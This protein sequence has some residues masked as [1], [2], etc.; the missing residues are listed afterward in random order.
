MKNYIHFFDKSGSDMNLETVENTITSLYD[1]SNVVYESLTGS[2]FFPKV[3]AGLIESQNFYL[4]QDVI[5]PSNYTLR[6]L[7]GSIVVTAGNP[8]V[9]GTDTEF[10]SLYVGNKIKIENDDY[11]ITSIM[12]DETMNVSSY[13]TKDYDTTNFYLYEYK[14]YVKPRTSTGTYSE[15]LSVSIPE[16]ST[17]IDDTFDKEV[18]FVYDIDYS[19]SVPWIKK[20]RESTY[21]L[22]DGS[23][24]SVDEN[25]G[26]VILSDIST[27]PLQINIGISADVEYVYDEIANFVLTKEYQESLIGA[28]ID[29]DYDVL[30]VEGIDHEFYDVSIFYLEGGIGSSTF[31]SESVDVIE[32]GTSGSNTY[33]K[34]EKLDSHP[35]TSSNFSKYR[36]RW[37]NDFKLADLVLYGEIEGEDERLKMVLEN[38][39]KKLDYANEYIFRDSD[40]YE[41]SPDYV[42]LNKKRKELLLEGDNIYP[43]LG[44]YKALLNIINFFGYYDMET[45]EYFLNVDESSPNYNKYFQVKI[46]KNEDERE[47]LKGIWSMLPSSVYKKTSLF[48][49]F[50]KINEETGEYDEYGIPEVKDSYDFSSEEIL[51]KLF[52]LKEL[53]KK[54]YLPLN[55][56]IYDITGEGIYFKRIRLDSWADNLCTRS[57][58]LGK[59]PVFSVYPETD[60]YITDI[61]R[62]DDFYK[63]SIFAEQGLTGFLNEDPSDPFVTPATY[64]GTLS[65]LYD[66]TSLIGYDSFRRSIYDSDGNFNDVVDIQ[67][68]YFPEGI[69]D[70]TFNEKAARKSLIPDSEGILTGAPILLESFF[71]ITYDEANFTFDNISVFDTSGNPLNTNRWTYDNIGMG[72]YIDMRWKVEKMEDSNSSGF[73]YDSGRRTIESFVENVKGAT[74]FAMNAMALCDVLDGSIEN[75]RFTGGCGYYSVPIVKVNAPP[76]YSNSSATSASNIITVS[77]TEGLGIGMSVTVAG[78]TGS[79]HSGTVVTEILGF[80]T[81]MV[82]TVPDDELQGA[83]IVGSGIAPEIHAEIL[84]GFVIALDVISSGL[85][86]SSSPEIKIAAPE[87]TYEYDRRILNAIALPYT[88]TYSISL[89]NYDVTNSFTLEFQKYEVK[90]KAVDFSAIFK[91]KVPNMTIDESTMTYDEMNGLWYYQNVS[92]TTFDEMNVSFDSFGF[93]AFLNEDFEFLPVSPTLISIDRENLLIE[94]EEDLISGNYN[95]IGITVGDDIFFKR[96][97]S[98]LIFKNELIEI[99]NVGYDVYG[100]S[101]IAGENVIYSS[102]SFSEFFGVGCF[103]RIN[104]EW[105]TVS[106]I[107]DSRF[108]IEETLS[109][110]FSGESGKFILSDGTV[111]VTTDDDVGDVS[112]YSRMI[113]SDNDSYEDIQSDLSYYCYVDFLEKN[114]NELTVS[115]KSFN[116]KILVEKSIIENLYVSNGLF[117]GTYSLEITNAFISNEHTFL[118]V[119]DPTNELYALDGNFSV[120]F[121]D[122]DADYAENRIGL[123]SMFMNNM[124]ESTFEEMTDSSFIGCMYNPDVLCGFVIT[125]I[126]PG[127]S[128][129]IDENDPFFFSGDQELDSSQEGLKK[130]AIELN[131]SKNSGIFK[132]SYHVLPDDPLYVVDSVGNNLFVNIDASYG[133][134]SIVL[135]GIPSNLEENDHVWVGNEW[136]KISSISDNTVVFDTILYYDVSSG[137][138]PF[139]PYNYHRQ[140]YENTDIFR[141]YYFFIHGKGKTSSNEELSYVTMNGNVS[142]EWA[143]HPSKTNT[144]PLL[145]SFLQKD[146]CG[147]DF[148]CQ[149]HLYKKWVYEG[150]DYPPSEIDYD[151][152]SDSISEESRLSYIG[153]LENPFFVSSTIVTSTQATVT[154]TTPIIFSANSCKIPGKHDFVWTISNDDTDEI[155]VQSSNSTFVWNFTK[156]GNFSVSLELK[157][158]NDNVCSIKKKSMICVE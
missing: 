87:V 50:Y 77:S 125:N 28:S 94:L 91:S 61:R 78:G 120:L 131:S 92:E 67:W 20:S 30:M 113:I 135:S 36:L 39:G 148:V 105:V 88:G 156:T 21:D 116:A 38:F 72:E 66:G 76:V 29:S 153:E 46:P 32:I 112:M 100:L 127:G 82:N 106:E 2:V 75:V 107:E 147:E 80:E 83:S 17:A 11:E 145:N 42:L 5:G 149:R 26:R 144:F 85:G 96:N 4:L 154:Q 34:I 1:D 73:N 70:S 48:G 27:I 101:G 142:G 24:D 60:S 119:N 33:I 139:L 90:S 35:V 122:F 25:T 43:Y 108:Y 138:Y 37:T 14:S 53:L 68:D 152:V 65:S 69:S 44:S 137:T 130:G 102:Y 134:S 63:D 129:T 6:K 99:G 95:G 71:D 86:Y 124:T 16:I 126:N 109:S 54:E 79:F 18:F 151:M 58:N 157:D 51:I 128:I 59:R 62:M 98:D 3:S 117:A 143:A 8:T 97:S 40:I 115:M 15:T 158:S 9:I 31:F 123:E 155:E 136:K 133:D 10:T 81:F 141:Q 84:D 57:L 89:W 49:L 13:P 104:G 140:I 110:S 93:D 55:A 132:Y 121:C 23:L 12:D 45:K 118:K 47:K 19:E 56:R 146:E 52:G 111:T 114:G 103:V 22:D 64:S 7:K 74:A 150:S 41:D